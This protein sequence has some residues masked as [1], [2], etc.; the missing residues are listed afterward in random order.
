MYLFTTN[1]KSSSSL[2]RFLVNTVVPPTRCIVAFLLLPIILLA[3]N[4]FKY[5][6]VALGNSSDS[7]NNTG[8]AISLYI[9]FPA[10]NLAARGAADNPST[11][12][13]P[14]TNTILSMKPLFLS[15]PVPTNPTCSLAIDTAVSYLL[16]P[17]NIST[18]AN[19]LFNHD[20]NMF[21]CFSAPFTVYSVVF[22]NAS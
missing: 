21:V 16:S 1:P 22:P 18:F 5:N 2:S 17:A 14:F 20:A 7:D 19:S 3:C 15:V 4:S 11:N 13:F 12:D 10:V 6:F 9:P 8:A